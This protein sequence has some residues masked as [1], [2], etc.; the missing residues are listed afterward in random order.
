MLALGEEQCSRLFGMM[1]EDEIKEVSS[2]MSA[3][4][5]RACRCWSSTAVHR[6]R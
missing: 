2:A 5:H 6:I 4:R 1:H 3:T